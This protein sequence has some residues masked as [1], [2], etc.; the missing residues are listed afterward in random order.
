LS[1]PKFNVDLVEADRV[2]WQLLPDV[3]GG[4][5]N[6]LQVQPSALHFEPNADD[7]VG[8]AEAHL[9]PGHFSEEEGD[10]LGAHQILKLHLILL[11]RL[12]EL[13]G[14]AQHA[15]AALRV[16]LK[17]HRAPRVLQV[18][19]HALHAALL[20]RLLHDAANLVLELVQPQRQQLVQR[21]SHVH[22]EVHLRCIA[23]V[24]FLGEVAN[25]S[26]FLLGACAQCFI[27][28]YRLMKSLIFFRLLLFEKF[29]DFTSDY[30]LFGIQSSFI[31]FYYLFNFVD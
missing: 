23:T 11:E 15:A 17:R 12:D 7:L 16:A 10:V 26:L 20:D 9:P 18:F 4:E 28:N 31:I 1:H 30:Y 19:Q 21:R 13:L 24:L 2:V 3:L 29:D 25:F 14:G 5:K 22:H 27:D 8:V 6:G